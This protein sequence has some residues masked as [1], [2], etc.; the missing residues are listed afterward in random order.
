[1]GIKIPASK[2]K[3]GLYTSGNEYIYPKSTKYYKGYYYKINGKSYVG[4]DYD[5]NTPQQEIIF[6]NKLKAINNPD[7]LLYNVLAGIKQGTTTPIASKPVKS[8]VLSSIALANKQGLNTDI[9]VNPNID[10]QA[11]ESQTS[12]QVVESTIVTNKRYLYRVQA[13]FPPPFSKIPPTYKFGESKTQ[14]DLDTISKKPNVIT[15]TVTET[16]I[17]NQKPVFDDKELNAAEK[18]MPGLKQFLGVEDSGA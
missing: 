7:S 12:T 9:G 6:A 5:P 8:T 3:K 13:T 2:I 11:I 18:K 10:T 14:E 16:V 15:A 1:M 17:P 4:K